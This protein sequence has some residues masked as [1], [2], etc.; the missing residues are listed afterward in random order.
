MCHKPEHSVPHKPISQMMPYPP[1]SGSSQGKE[2]VMYSELSATP[3]N[4]GMVPS[5]AHLY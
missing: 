5:H 1:E 3:A 2:W 4:T